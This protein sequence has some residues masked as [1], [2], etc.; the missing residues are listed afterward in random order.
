MPSR[1]LNPCDSAAGPPAIPLASA[2]R[3]V[4]VMN[5]CPTSSPRTS[6]SSQYD[7]EATSSRSSFS[8]NQRKLDEP[9][10]REGKKHLLETT[11]RVDDTGLV[12]ELVEI[13]FTNHPAAT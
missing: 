13:P 6:I 10:S 1:G 12:P 2:Y 9:R 3:L 4:D 5:A 11:T 7:R 8:R